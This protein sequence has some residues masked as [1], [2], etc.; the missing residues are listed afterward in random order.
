MQ[1]A[2]QFDR[3]HA[4]CAVLK[5]V[6]VRSVVCGHALLRFASKLFGEELKCGRL[7][8]PPFGACRLVGHLSG[9]A[10]A[11]CTLAPQRT[12]SSDMARTR[13]PII[14]SVW[15]GDGVKRSRSVPFGTV[16]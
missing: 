13:S 14:A 8:R 16:G 5:I 2:I 4:A 1:E 7:P 12:H 9:Q 6:I 10:A 15:S 11:V 3:V